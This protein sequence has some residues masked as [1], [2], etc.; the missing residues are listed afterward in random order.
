MVYR[1]RSSSSPLTSQT[2]GFVGWRHAATFA[3]LCSFSKESPCSPRIEILECIG[4]GIGFHEGDS[5]STSGLGAGRSVIMVFEFAAGSETR[6]FEK[7]MWLERSAFVRFL[8]FR[9]I[10]LSFSKS[11]PQ[12]FR[13]RD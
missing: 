13:S 4:V 8:S 6:K 11:H 2:R 3:S 1:T 7:R 12:A 10:K 9:V 5:V